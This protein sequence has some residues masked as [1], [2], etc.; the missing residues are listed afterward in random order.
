[1]STTKRR[2]I[3]FGASGLLAVAAV[4]AI[5]LASGGDDSSESGEPEIVTASQL[6]ELAAE[7]DQPVYWLG[8]RPGTRYELTDDGERVYVRYL[9]GDAA[10]GDERSSFVAVATYPAADGLAELRH[11]AAKRQGAQLVHA[12][13]GATVL[14]DPSSPDNAH[15]VYPDSDVQVEVYSPV[16]GQALRLASS[17]ELERV[18]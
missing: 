5:V 14:I 11:A 17:G 8:E 7:V 15:L 16:P 18:R 6:S 4:V 13:D 2:W 10:A 3:L 1:M 12:A 9:R